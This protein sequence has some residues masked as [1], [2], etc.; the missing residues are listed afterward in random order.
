MYILWLFAQD[1]EIPGKIDKYKI[2][3]I[4]KETVSNGMSNNLDEC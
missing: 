3:Y 4:R 1:T 2:L